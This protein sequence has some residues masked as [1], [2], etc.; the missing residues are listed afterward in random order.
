MGLWPCKQPLSRHLACC[1]VLGARVCVSVT[2]LLCV[3]VCVCVHVH[4]PSVR[5]CA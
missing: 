5:M 4:V 3:C 2:V 1:E